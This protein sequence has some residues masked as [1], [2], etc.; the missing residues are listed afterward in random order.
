MLRLAEFSFIFGIQ[1]LAASR[2]FGGPT[3]AI[4]DVSTFIGS[5]GPSEEDSQPN[6]LLGIY[7]PD[8]WQDLD[9]SDWLRK[10][11]QNLQP[12]SHEHNVDT[13]NCQP[14]G[15]PWTTTFLRIAQNV[16][17]S[18]GCTELNACLDNPPTSKDIVFQKADE[19]ARYRYIC[20][21]IYGITRSICSILASV[22]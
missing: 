11:H 7:D 1:C 21:N 13:R 17:D 18:S 5:N 19:A 3:T 2:K 8:C 20:Y 15:E 9:L 12:C 16:T 6:C 4:A 14:A 22:Y 10:W